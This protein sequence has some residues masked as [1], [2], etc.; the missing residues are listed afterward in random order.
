M[1]Q[2]TK[3]DAFVSYSRRDEHLVE[4]LAS[5]LKD[6]AQ[7]NV[8]FDK[9]ELIAGKPFS[10]GMADGL[11][12]SKT[13]VVING[14]NTLEG[15]FKK[16]VNR[17]L[18][19]Q[20]ENPS[21]S[22]ISVILPGA[23][24]TFIS[25]FLKSLTWVKFDDNLGEQ[26]PFHELVC[27]IKGIPPGREHSGT[28]PA[29]KTPNLQPTDGFPKELT[30]NFPKLRLDQVIGRSADVEDLHKRLFDNKQVVLMNGMGGIGK[31][32]VAEVYVT[33]N[34][35][36]YKHI[37]WVSQLSD[38]FSNDL[39]NSRGLLS[40]LHITKQDKNLDQLFDELLL[41]LKN[42]PDGPCLMVIDN[43]TSTLSKLHKL[44]P[45]QPKWHILVTSR[46]RI[47]HF[48]VKELGFLSETDAVSLF[49]KHYKKHKIDD[50]AIK[51]IVKNLDYHTLTIEI[52]AKTAQHQN[53]SPEAI[54]KAVEEDMAADIAVDH[55]SEKIEKIT[56]Y[57]CS[58]FKLSN[59]DDDERWLLTQF[60]CLPP[61]FHTEEQ[62]KELIQPDKVK[63]PI[64]AKLLSN[65]VNN[66]WLLY[67][68]SNESYKLHRIL[69]DVIG[70]SISKVFDTVEPLITCITNN[71]SIDQTKDNPVDKFIWVPYGNAILKQFDL[72]D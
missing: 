2:Q 53:K 16:E 15:W 6:A 51:E 66:G 4:S 38:D 34:L 26:R 18:S 70:A 60:A 14:S 45:G 64:I 71:L 43:A 58:I 39:I 52:L 13:C 54:N 27:G 8:W 41:A 62:S 7:L 46:E 9:W 20:A 63:E 56:S 69:S 3:F 59:L 44:L 50:N 30:L 28:S 48:D 12:A 29:I 1:T 42:I 5:K 19:I 11:K 33:Q 32:T 65:L 47:S 22:V 23:N 37:V 68:A 24:P 61:E 17:A 57:L 25:D 31:T 55:S 36:C 35:G 40:N 67:N 10:D 72:I 21:F 49:K